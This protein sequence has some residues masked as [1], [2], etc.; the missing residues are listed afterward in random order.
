MYIIPVVY[1]FAQPCLEGNVS[2]VSSVSHWLSFL[3]NENQN[4]KF[5]T[6]VQNDKKDKNNM[7]YDL[8]GIKY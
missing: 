8:R 3:S 5:Q 7:T 2:V 6:E 4:E 1:S